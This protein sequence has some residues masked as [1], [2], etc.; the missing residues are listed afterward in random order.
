LRG[1]ADDFV[2]TRA[3][4]GKTA[5]DFD[6]PVIRAWEGSGLSPLPM[7]LQGVLMGDFVAAAEAA[8]RYDLINNPAGQI[9][10]MLKKKRPAREIMLSMVREAE[11]VLDRLGSLRQAA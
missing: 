4:T 11:A 10:G 1:S 8:G 5:R 9:S 3:Y 2:V 6:N 7:P